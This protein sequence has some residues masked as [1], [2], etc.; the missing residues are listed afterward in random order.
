MVRPRCYMPA[1]LA[2]LR[3]G[4][5]PVI[6]QR[7]GHCVACDVLLTGVAWEARRL[8]DGYV[9]SS[10]RACSSACLIAAVHWFGIEMAV[11]REVTDGD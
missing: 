1:L 8:V 5:Q 7:D 10:V 4:R 2:V 11:A 3:A 6:P 9:M